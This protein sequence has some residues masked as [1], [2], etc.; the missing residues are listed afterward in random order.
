MLSDMLALD[1]SALICDFAETYQIYDMWSFPVDYVARLAVGLRDNSRIKTKLGNI[2][3]PIDSVMQAMAV[4]YLA[5]LL[6]F[7]SEDGRKNRNRPKSFTEALMGLVQESNV[8]G[9]DSRSSACR[10]YWICFREAL[11]SCIRFPK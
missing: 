2:K 11:E 3:V 4:D 8:R 1:E 9:F 10:E 5:L 6:W 7:Q